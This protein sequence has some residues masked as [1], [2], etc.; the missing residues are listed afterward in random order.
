MESNSPAVE[1]SG[2]NWKYYKGRLDRCAVSLKAMAEKEDGMTPALGWWL[3]FSQGRDMGRGGNPT[4]QY[5][6]Q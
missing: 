6:T 5:G 1:K 2:C 4:I 3:S